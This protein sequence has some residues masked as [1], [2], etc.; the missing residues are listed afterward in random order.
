MLSIADSSYSRSVVLK[1]LWFKKKRQKT[2][3]KQNTVNIYSVMYIYVFPVWDCTIHL[4]S[5]LS[6]GQGLQE[7]IADSF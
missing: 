6:S 3:I 7:K 4:A 2:N 1:C 5:S